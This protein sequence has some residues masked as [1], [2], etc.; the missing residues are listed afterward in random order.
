MMI[1]GNYSVMLNTSGEA[2][3]TSEAA[4]LVQNGCRRRN[5]VAAGDRRSLLNAV[6]KISS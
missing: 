2:A 5:Q 6:F 1:L 3:E 4:E